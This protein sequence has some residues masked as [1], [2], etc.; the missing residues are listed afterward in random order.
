MTR[1]SASGV[2]VSGALAAALWLA[3]AAGCGADGP[4][5]ARADS[6]SPPARDAE[7]A[8]TA[9]D[10][11]WHR[12][13]DYRLEWRGFPVMG[14]G[15]APDFARYLDGGLV[16][17]KDSSNNLTILEDDT[18]RV[19]WGYRLGDP[20]ELWL[21][22][23]RVDDTLV[24][25]GQT[26]VLLFDIRDGKLLDR[27]QLRGLANT[28]PVVIDGNAIFGGSDG[29][30][31]AHNLT[32]GFREW[33][34]QL[35][36]A[37]TARPVRMNSETVGVVSQGGEVI[38][39][40]ADEGDSMGRRDRIFAGLANDPVTD[41]RTLYVASLD[42]SVWAFAL[43]DA[44]LLWRVRTEDRISAQPAVH[45]GRVYVYVPREGL[46]ALNA[47]T[48]DRVWSAPDVDG[49]VVGKRGEE[50]LVWDGSSITTLSAESGEVR[51]EVAVPGVVSV[52]TSGFEGGAL[53]SVD[54]SGRVSKFISAY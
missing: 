38:I 33:A 27:Q 31:L 14:R 28:P 48:G 15:A 25:G 7:T 30:V 39:L 32:V 44:R 26:E 42:Q 45:A 40:G 6:A 50:L 18:G 16:A 49:E 29:K 5:G 22:V 10:G 3:P 36:G 34:Y 37:I 1:T 54:P 35:D 19:R 53:Y 12:G 17:F 20:L 43:E 4:K 47:G 8:D 21:G 9:D 2:C 24:A 11:P 13:I 23:A 52:F 46:L 51:T 41:G